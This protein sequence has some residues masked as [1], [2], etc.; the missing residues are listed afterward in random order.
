MNKQLEEIYEGRIDNLQKMVKTL[1]ETIEIQNERI[2]IAK[3]RV[4]NHV[5]CTCSPEKRDIIKHED[6]RSYFC[7]NCDKEL[8]PDWEPEYDPEENS[9]I[10]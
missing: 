10:L 5:Y 3:D 7:E 8:D 9:E 6:G 4:E 2:S 1:K